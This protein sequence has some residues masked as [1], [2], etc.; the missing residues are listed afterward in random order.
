M[1]DPAD[2]EI[3]EL[4]RAALTHHQSGQFEQALRLYVQILRQ[5]PDHPDALHLTGFLFHSR[6][7][8]ETGLELIMK[9]IELSP[10]NYLYR[11]NLGVVL[12]EQGKLDEAKLSFE[13]A[14]SLKPDDHLALSN[15]G[16]IHYITGSPGEAESFYKKSLQAS[17]GNIESLY[18][19]GALYAD[20]GKN[21]DAARCFFEALGRGP[22][23]REMYKQLG[24]GFNRIGMEEE[25][26]RCFVT[27]H[28]SKEGGGVESP[29]RRESNIWFRK[30]CGEFRGSVL[31]IGSGND[32]DKKDNLY[33]Q[34]F[35]SADSYTR[36]DCSGKYYPDLVGDVEDLSGLIQDASFDVVFC[37]WVLEH[38]KNVQAAVGEI[39]RILKTGGALVF[40]LPLNLAYHS[41]PHDHHRFTPDGISG[42]LQAG[43]TI[44][45]LQPAGEGTDMELDPRLAI[46][47]NT[48]PD[49]APLGYM[50]IAVKK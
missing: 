8:S 31:S 37:I 15:L 25:S 7:E 9:A 20:K 11:I 42:L 30:V 46:I 28:R 18:F 34:Y 24:I 47:G 19:L 26:L 32:F 6:G 33:R 43:F 45:E 14:L 40:G 44:R 12:R 3:D 13:K 50:G 48:L 39:H 36:L 16:Y 41:F 23:T 29:L 21:D 4:L 22:G 38:V 5:R 27:A 1:I 17:P 35:D 10:N 2:T 49:P